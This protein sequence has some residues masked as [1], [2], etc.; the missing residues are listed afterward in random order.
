MSLLHQGKYVDA[1]RIQREVHG[2]R[3]RVLGAE[4]PDTLTSASNLASS[5]ED[6]GKHAEAA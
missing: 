4:H 1:E 2:V 6:L 3:K 5:L